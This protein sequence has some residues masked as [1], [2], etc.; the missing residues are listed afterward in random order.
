VF[1]GSA[2]MTPIQHVSNALSSLTQMN[3]MAT[4][5]ALL[6]LFVMQVSV[7]SIFYHLKI[8]KLF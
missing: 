2:Q 5:N 3:P 4:Q 7:S 8:K 6:A 1:F